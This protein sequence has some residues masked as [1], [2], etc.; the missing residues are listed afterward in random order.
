MN[1]KRNNG[2]EIE[3]IAMADNKTS[4]HLTTLL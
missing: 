4:T 1:V 2:V 3:I